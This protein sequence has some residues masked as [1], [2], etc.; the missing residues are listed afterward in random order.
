MTQLRPVERTPAAF[1]E[2][3]PEP[4]AHPSGGHPD[5]LR[6]IRVEGPPP[7][8]SLLE[9]EEEDEVFRSPPGPAQPNV[10]QGGAGA[11]DDD[12]DIPSFLRR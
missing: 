10:G 6:T 7:V 2:A 8:S 3:T 11:P 5:P 12:L 1:P 9:D 4:A